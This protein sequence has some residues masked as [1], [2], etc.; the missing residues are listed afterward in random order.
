MKRTTLTLFDL[1]DLNPDTPR[2][3]GWCGN[4]AATTRV[5]AQQNLLGVH[6]T[7]VTVT[8]Y[9]DACHRARSGPVCDHCAWYLAS[10]WWGPVYACPQRGSCHLWT[11]TLTDPHPKWNCKRHHRENRVVWQT[12]IGAA[13]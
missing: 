6:A 5:Y 9:R 3:C 4:R 10:S 1:T 12:P 7:F 2:T 11:H 13:A 8:W